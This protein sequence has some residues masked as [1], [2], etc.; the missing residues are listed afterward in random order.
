M[1]YK[2]AFF[3]ESQHEGY[4]PE[5]NTNNRTDIAWQI[6][7]K[8]Y[9]IPLK[10][11][12][13]VVNRLK[14]KSMSFDIGIII[15]PKDPMYLNHL[16][17]INLIETARQICK[18]VAFMQEGPNWL[19]QDYN[20]HLI[21]MFYRELIK[22]DFILC[23]NQIDVNYYKGLTSLRTYTMPT[24][25]IENT[26]KN[27]TIEENKDENVIIGGN[28]VSWYNGFDSYIIA[29]EFNS[30]IF[31]PSMGRRQ[32]EEIYIRNLTLI[33]YTDWTDWMLTLNKF[34]YAV[35][36]M[37][38]Y[39][40]GSFALNCAYLG[41]PCIGYEY[42]D[43]QRILHHPELTVQESDILS[44]RLAAQKLKND[45]D[46]YVEASRLARHNYIK[47]YNMDSFIRNMESVFENELSRN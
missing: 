13:N 16:L 3:T 32:Q 35:H 39:A 8:S 23:H 19:Y 37:R 18:K 34:K 44:A 4:I 42:L 22:F 21:H 25:M 33:P 41:I 47:L 40:A 24:I 43:T 12:S 38:T 26:I 17:S 10:D 46:F 31:C 28:F 5:N 14:N 20:V 7:L 29:S 30:N 1:K 9:H 6:A 45:K 15:L 27:I 2:V 36:L 11:V